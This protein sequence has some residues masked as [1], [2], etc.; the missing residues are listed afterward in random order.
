MTIII[1]QGTPKTTVN[2][3]CPLFSIK[4]MYE[5]RKDDHK[6]GKIKRMKVNSPFVISS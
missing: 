6:N 2:T 3:P 5:I 1:H 4:Y